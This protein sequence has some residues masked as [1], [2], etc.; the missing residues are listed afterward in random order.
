MGWKKKEKDLSPEEA[1][2]LAKKELAP[3]W[4]G[5]GPRIVGLKQEKGSVVL[6]LDP[7]FI[8][9]TWLLFFI[10][11]TDFLGDFILSYAKEW[12]LRYQVHGVEILMIFLPSYGYFKDVKHL[13][14]RVEGLHL[15]FIS[16][17]DCEEAIVQA[18]QAEAPPKVILLDKGNRIFEHGGQE[19]LDQAELKLQSFLR[20]KDPGLPLLPVF[21]LQQRVQDVGRLEFGFKPKRGTLTAF[22][23]PGFAGVDAATG[24]K[25]GSFQAP[26][27]G[28]IKPGEVF[29]KGNWSQDAE[30]LFTA[31][32]QAWMAFRGT[33]SRV[34]LVMQSLAQTL[35]E[36]PVIVVEVGGDPAHEVL[37][38]KDLISDDLGRSIV[39]VTQARLHH[40]LVNLP[41]QGQEITLRFVNAATAPIGIHGIRLGKEDQKVE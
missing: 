14:E 7:E 9:K 41:A 6:P 28:E 26:R 33:G 27:S 25:A 23:P 18:F 8:K 39:K 31:D 5:S 38:G 17:V 2:A 11:L 30:K 20:Q 4:F 13:Q 1:V 40:I 10:D 22:A 35:A 36:I 16:M 29:L 15:D 3:F 32:S 37:A 34:S 21:Q 12:H 24:L 19:W